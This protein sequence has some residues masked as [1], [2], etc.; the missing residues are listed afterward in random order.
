MDIVGL[1]RAFVLLAILVGQSA[2]SLLHVVKPLAVIYVPVREDIDSL[3]VHLAIVPVPFEDSTVCVLIFPVPVHLAAHPIAFILLHDIAARAHIG[4]N[5]PSVAL[6]VS[7][8]ALVDVALCVA[9]GPSSV[10]FAIQPL[11]IVL[12]IVGIRQCPVAVDAA[13]LPGALI[14]V[15]GGKDGRTLPMDS[16]LDPLAFEDGSVCVGEAAVP[17]ALPVDPL[18]LIVFVA[19]VDEFPLAMEKTVLNLAIVAVASLGHRSTKS[20]EVVRRSAQFRAFR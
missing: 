6:V 18:A 16:V 4:D 9:V 5:A 11:A 7:P 2:V 3:P 20:R 15:P 1:P 10:H 12:V 17:F 14:A 8:L 13:I 19:S